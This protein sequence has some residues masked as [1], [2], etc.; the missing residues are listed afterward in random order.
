MIA[1]WPVLVLQMMKRQTF[2]QRRDLPQLHAG[3]QH[4]W[5]RQCGPQFPGLFLG[6]PE[7][8]GLLSLGVPLL[9]LKY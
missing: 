1:E 8:S 3:G 2:S 6:H 5:C 4:G 7:V 9:L